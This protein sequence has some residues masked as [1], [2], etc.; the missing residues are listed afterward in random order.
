M[1]IK[2]NCELRQA[3]DSEDAGPDGVFAIR[4]AR[5]LAQVG[6]FI[7]YGAP[8]LGAVGYVDRGL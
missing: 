6:R 7:T 1:S 2:G 3:S 8:V 4:F 5:L